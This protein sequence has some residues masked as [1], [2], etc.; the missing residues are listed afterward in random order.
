M[1][2]LTATETQSMPQTTTTQEVHPQSEESSQ[3]Q[4]KAESPMRLADIEAAMMAESRNAALAKETERQ[5]RDAREAAEAD[6]DSTEQQEDSESSRL[7]KSLRK[8]GETTVSE[9]LD[10][11]GLD[12]SDLSN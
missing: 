3:P 2:P 4:A 1:E 12:P 8:Y 7:P 5:E 11:F 6:Q 10:R 9:M